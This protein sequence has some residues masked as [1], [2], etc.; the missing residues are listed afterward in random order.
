MSQT[1]GDDNDDDD[2]PYPISI[3]NGYTVSKVRFADTKAM[4]RVARAAQSVFRVSDRRRK[5]VPAV[6]LL[7]NVLHA[8]IPHGIRTAHFCQGGVREGFLFREL[9]PSVRAKD[10]LEAATQNVAPASAPTIYTMLMFS[11]PE[12][13]SRSRFLGAIGAHVIRAFANMLYVHA[14]MDKELASA[15]AL[16]STSTGLLSSTRGVSHE[17]RARLALMLESRYMGELPPREVRFRE[18]LRRVIT[19]EEVW[20]AAYLGRVGYLISRLYPSVTVDESKPR[21]TLSSEWAV[22]LGKGKTRRV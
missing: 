7:I 20:W 9:T 13:S 1:G 15:S 2:I 5:Q 10:P 14:V 4:E 3:I 19:P 12:P 6:A 17:D 21:L 8:A 18:A 11:F 22:D 16:Y